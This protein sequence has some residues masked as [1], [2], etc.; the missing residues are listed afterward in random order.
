MTA[1]D[2]LR[3]RMSRTKEGW[4]PADVDRL[5]RGFGFRVREG[6]KHRIY[7]HPRFPWLRATVARSSPLATGY[8]ETALELLDRLDVLSMQQENG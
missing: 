6:A 7:S 3:A 4:S 8:V 5:Y 1:A 2:K